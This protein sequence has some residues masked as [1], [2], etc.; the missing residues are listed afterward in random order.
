MNQSIPRDSARVE[1]GLMA[2]RERVEQE[3]RGE[4]RWVSPVDE[5]EDDS[6]VR[7]MTF[8]DSAEH[9]LS[10]TRP[11]L[12]SNLGYPKKRYCLHGHGTWRVEKGRQAPRDKRFP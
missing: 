12:R 3:R 7:S 8:V 2:L 9:L 10:L 1:K 5:A 4:G 11:R 6:H